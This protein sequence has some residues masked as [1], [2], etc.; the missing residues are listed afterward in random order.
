VSLDDDPETAASGSSRVRGPVRVPPARPGA[1]R[2][3]LKYL[4]EVKA[5]GALLAAGAVLV[6]L[7]VPAG[8]SARV[9]AH[10]RHIE[11]RP[12]TVAADLNLGTHD[13]YLTSVQFEEPDLATL[14]VAKL[15]LSRL[16]VASTSYG[17][18][19]HG[20]LSGGRLSADF[21]RVGSVAVRFRPSGPARERRPLKGC[22]GK[23]SRGESGRW[24]GKVSLRGE[25]G[26]FAVSTDS[27]G[28]ELDR[29]FRLRCHVKRRLPRPRPESLRERIEPHIGASLISIILGT[30]SSLEAVN[31]EAGRV[32]ALRAA[33]ANGRG[34]GSEVE[35]GAFEYQGGMPVGRWSSSSRLR[36]GR[37]SP[38][39]PENVRRPPP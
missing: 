7:A 23:S 38:P 30:A 21:G 31:T 37:W 39:S 19:F 6:A 13:G 22:E 34:P 16:K 12:P 3:S 33:H 8:A 11:V 17:A 35:A 28:G 26:Y 15:D 2:E 24:V 29:T 1:T 9:G 14:V 10:R 36:P 20:S 5:W 4:G 25:G 27:V 18:H 32:V